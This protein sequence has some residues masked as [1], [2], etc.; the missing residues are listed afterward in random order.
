MLVLV[1]ALLTV[2][3]ASS[4][5][6]FLHQR[7]QLATLSATISSSQAD[8]DRL[9]QERDRW[10]D[11]AFVRTVAHQRLGWVLPGEIGFQV[12]DEHGRP[13][14]HTDSL[15]A[16]DSVTGATRPLWWQSAW[17]SVLAAGRPQVEKGSVPPPATSIRPGGSSV[18]TGR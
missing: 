11:P 16:Q 3:Y 2:S 15:P 1:L 18:R 12:L 5:R 6:A 14:S 9:T 10:R 8:V 4:M 7:H 17:G 13:L